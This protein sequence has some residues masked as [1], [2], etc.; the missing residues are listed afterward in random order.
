MVKLLI[1]IPC[2]NEGNT[3]PLLLEQLLNL[4]L[5]ARYQMEIAVVNDCSKDD[6][7]AM[8]DLY[9]IAVLDL[10]VNLGIGGAVQ[11][12][13]RYARQNNFDLAVQIDGDGQHPP[14]ELIK[15]LDFQE[16]T[17]S[18]VVIGSRFLDEGGFKSSFAR[19]MGIRYLHWLNKILT[20][21]SVYDSTSGFRLMDRAAIEIAA[22]KYPDEFPEPASLVL[23]SKLGLTVQEVSVIM[24]ERLAGQSSI[25]NFKSVYYMLKV[26][27]SML[28]IYIRK[29]N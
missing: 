4:K 8:A 24:S 6:T 11:T 15:L 13:I 9:P 25:R 26:T 10:L 7:K 29:S 19:R 3:L 23:F 2:Y 21:K 5:P 12:G 18:N 22:E 16:S 27:I 20:G 28:F 17:K 1:I 14:W